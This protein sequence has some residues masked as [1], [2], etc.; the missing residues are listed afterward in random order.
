MIFVNYPVR[1]VLVEANKCGQQLNTDIWIKWDGGKQPVSD[2]T[3]V[4]VKFRNRDSGSAPSS[5]FR[6]DHLGVDYDIVAYRVVEDTPKVVGGPHTWATEFPAGKWEKVNSPTDIL[7]WFGKEET[8]N[9]YL[10][11]FPYDTID[12]YRVLS[13]YEVT[14]PC[15]QHAVKKLLCT[16]IRG[17]KGK[18]EDIQ[19]V[20]DSLKRWQEMRKE[21]GECL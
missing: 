15:I 10:R 3:E 11:G 18:N 9:K 2:G 7:T 16:G 1:E 17:Y 20:I 14:D 6:W 19:D 13:V 5:I 12:I 21:E 4:E 8:P